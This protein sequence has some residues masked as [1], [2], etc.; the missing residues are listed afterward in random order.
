MNRSAQFLKQ[1]SVRESVLDP[2]LKYNKLEGD[3][4][5]SYSRRKKQ[6]SKHIA[7]I[8]YDRGRQPMVRGPK[9]ALFKNMMALFKS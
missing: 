6:L 4:R 3:Y 9:V 5:I 8:L 2:N 7:R 1:D